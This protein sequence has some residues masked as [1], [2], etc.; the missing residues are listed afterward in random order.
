MIIV[1]KK[2]DAFSKNITPSSQKWECVRFKLLHTLCTSCFFGL[3]RRLHRSGFD[4]DTGCVEVG[5][6][7]SVHVGQK[8]TFALPT[9]LVG[10]LFQTSRQLVGKSLLKILPKL[11]GIF[12]DIF[13]ATLARIFARWFFSFKC[14]NKYRKLFLYPLIFGFYNSEYSE[15]TYKLDRLAIYPYNNGTAVLHY[16]N[17]WINCSTILRS[18]WAWPTVFGSPKRYRSVPPRIWFCWRGQ[19]EAEP[20]FDFQSRLHRTSFWSESDA[21]ADFWCSV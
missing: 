18:C 12:W 15:R 6:R 7:T 17:N 4:F 19:E 2:R 9:K 1:N 13:R 21:P 3:L 11:D 5:F 16:I 10:S 14:P 20:D 8:L